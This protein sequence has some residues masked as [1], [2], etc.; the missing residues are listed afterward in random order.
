MH[1]A[2]LVATLAAALPLTACSGGGKTTADGQVAGHSLDLLGA[3]WGGPFI[4]LMDRD[5]SCLDMAW[6]D[7]YYEEGVD[8]V[9]SDLTAM[10]FSFTGDTVAEGIYDVSGE[11][12]VAARFLVVDDGGFATYRARSGQIIVDEITPQDV[13]IGTYEIGFDEGDLSGELEV[14]WCVNIKD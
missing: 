11:A 6:V 1:R 13:V 9:G 10:Q 14:E 8:P 3:Y 4:V 7:R 2:I 12:V 5:W